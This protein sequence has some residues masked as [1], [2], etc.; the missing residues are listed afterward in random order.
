MLFIK[1][2]RIEIQTSSGLY[3]FDESFNDKV[4][5][6]WSRGNTVGKSSILSAIFYGLG[7]EEIIGGKGKVILSPVYRKVLKNK[8]EL[9][10]VLESKIY[11][12]ISNGVESNTILRSALHEF[13]SD[14][15]ATVYNSNYDSINNPVTS[16][17]DYYIH[18]NN[19]ATNQL[20]FFSYLENS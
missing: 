6:I 3:G 9:L 13:R 15:L 19:S 18:G 7:M 8:N 10:D 1:R 20:G 14:T 5:L 17:V 12:E 4:Q 11:L 2:I 16:S